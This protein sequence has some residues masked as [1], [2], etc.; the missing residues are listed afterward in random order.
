[1]K[2]IYKYLVLL[3]SIVFAASVWSECVASGDSNLQLQ[4]LG[5]G[6]PGGSGGRASSSYILWIDGVGRIMVDSGSG[7]KVNFHKSG[8]NFNDIDLVA[9]SH[10]HPDH[11]AELPAILWPRGGSFKISGPTAGGDFPSLGVFLN[12]MFGPD[13]AYPILDS[14]V[15]I[16]TTTAV[17]AGS[18][19]ATEVWREGDI[20]VLGKGVPHGN[21]PAIGYRVDV[22]DKSIVFSSDQN[23]SDASFSEFAKDTD[24]LVIHMTIAEDANSTLHAK[25]SVWG[26]LAEAANAGHVVVSHIGEATPEG[27]EASL[28]ILQDNYSGQITVAD[29]LSCVEVK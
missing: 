13:G 2:S 7:T 28:K 10:L 9:L 11:S 5:S 25:P 4:V 18:E 24:V 21:V 27:L 15:Q 26:Q 14:R 29:D 20:L 19:E 16:E 6:G 22:G 3:L 23:G 17:D 8:A 12:R 1:L